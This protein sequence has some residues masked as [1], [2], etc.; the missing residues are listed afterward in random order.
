MELQ[1]TDVSLFTSSQGDA[2]RLTLSQDG[3]SATIKLSK[4]D[5]EDVY[6]SAP[7]FLISLPG[8]QKGFSVTVAA[9]KA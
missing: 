8:F 7:F 9:Y 1:L 5:Q 4:V 3:I 6:K 2:R